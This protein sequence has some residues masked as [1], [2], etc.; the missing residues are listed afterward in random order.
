MNKIENRDT[1]SIQTFLQGKRLIDSRHFGCKLTSALIQFLKPDSESKIRLAFIR[2]NYTNLINISFTVFKIMT[3]VNAIFYSSL[4][5]GREANTQETFR[6][7]FSLFSCHRKPFRNIVDRDKNKADSCWK[8]TLLIRFSQ[9]VGRTDR[10]LLTA[11]Y[12]QT[13]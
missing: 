4:Q 13:L 3:F 5:C 9:L 12:L 6:L 7:H 11:L 2:N 1:N 8:W 10:A